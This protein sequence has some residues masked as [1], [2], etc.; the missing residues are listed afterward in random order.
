MVEEKK[1][2][3][4]TTE[5]MSDPGTNIQG[6]KIYEDYLSTLNTPI[7]T[8]TAY[9]KMR[10][11]DYQVKRM[12]NVL[13]A[14]IKGGKFRF[15]AKDENDPQQIHQI[16]YKNNFYKQWADQT[17]QNILDE[18]L[19]YPLFGFTIFE[20]YFKL[21]DDALF[22]KIFTLANM[23]FIKQSTIDKWDIVENKVKRI[24]QRVSTNAKFISKWIDGKD[25]IIFTNQREGNNFEGISILRAAYGPYIRKEL[26]LKLDMIG[27]ERMAIGTPIAFVPASYF[28]NATELAKLEGVLQAYT[29]HQKAYMIFSDRLKDEGF[30]IEDGSYNSEAIDRSI[31]REDQAMLDSIL[32]GFLA[33]GTA[34]SGGNAQNEGQMELYLNSLLFI[35]EHVAEILSNLAHKGYVMNFGEPEIRLDMSVSGIRRND[36]K[37]IM[38]VTRGYATSNIIEPDDRLEKYVRDELDLPEKDFE[39]S[40]KQDMVP[41]YKADQDEEDKANPNEQNNPEPNIDEG[42]E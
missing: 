10:R 34:K 5:R 1:D 17:W 15:L 19:T 35:A 24:Y 36:A 7:N 27:N 16:T 9:N 4:L 28:N 42:D 11:Q 14:P 41:D 40:R 12:E 6:Q 32:A 25:L 20:P 23:G 33:I 2:E 22:G 37:K 29:S 8:Y 13:T 39:S 38:E 18:I 26:Y 30:R 21:V 31:K 3:A